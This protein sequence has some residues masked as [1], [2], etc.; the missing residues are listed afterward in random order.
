[1]ERNFKSPNTNSTD[2]HISTFDYSAEFALAASNL[3]NFKVKWLVL[4]HLTI[5]SINSCL[6]PVK[7][8]SFAYFHLRLFGG[9]ESSSFQLTKFQSPMSRTVSFN[10]QFDPLTSLY[11][12]TRLICIFPPTTI[13]RIVH[14]QRSTNDNSQ[15][16]AQSSLN[17]Q[18]NQA[19]DLEKCGNSIHLHI[20]SFD[21]SAESP[22]AIHRRTRSRSTP[23]QTI[24]RPS[25][26]STD[27]SKTRIFHQIAYFHN[28]LFG[29][30]QLFGG[31]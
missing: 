26:Q 2:L 19:N 13:R 3:R 10:K 24:H 22:C 6:K 9:I 20:S 30:N 29:G 21:Y 31:N 15:R 8:R 23:H 5:N 25:T 27:T 4:F 17:E 1:M 7:F 28:R 12:E 14:L 11:D 16:K 18:Q